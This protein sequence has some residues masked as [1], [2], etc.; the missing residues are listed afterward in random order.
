MESTVSGIRVVIAD[1]E[2]L[3]RKLLTRLVGEHPE[4]TIVGSASDGETAR[5]VVEETAPDLV[6]LDIEMPGISGVDLTES[7]RRLDTRPYVVFVTAYDQYAIQAFDLDAL[8]YLVKP[9]EKGRFARSIE[10]AIQAISAARIRNL[11]EQIAG[12]TDGGKAAST[13]TEMTRY[14]VIRQGDELVRVQESDIFWLEAASQYVHVHTRDNRY[15]VAEPLKNYVGKLSPETFVRVHRSAAVN[16]N[17][18][19]RVLR[20]TNGVHELQLA[21]GAG[22]PLSRSRRKMVHDL[23][24]ISA[25]NRKAH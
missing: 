11:G 5:Q 14:V 19:E 13:V 21:N 4:M 15:L 24:T 10:R 7:W 8:D 23:L 18:V 22:V 3:A 20:K 25:K 6:Y 12:L 1:D 2:P 16:V 17:K 9:I